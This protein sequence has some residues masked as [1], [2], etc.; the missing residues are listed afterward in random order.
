MT[1]EEIVIT[2]TFTYAIVVVSA[3]VWIMLKTVELNKAI[4][5]TRKT[6]KK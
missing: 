4:N 2:I 5:E 1:I 6:F 3:M